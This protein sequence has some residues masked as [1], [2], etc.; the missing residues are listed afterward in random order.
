[1]KKEFNKEST[2]ATLI[3]N[4]VS[5]TGDPEKRRKI[6]KEI[7]KNLKWSGNYI[8]T[9][10]KKSAFHIAKTETAKGIKHIVICG[11]D[12]T[13]M[14]TLGAIVNK[15]ISLGIVPLGTGNLLAR[16]LDLPLDTKEALNIALFGN[17]REIDI[18]RANGM[19][20]SLIAGMGIDADIMKETKRE[21]K[22]A[23]GL[24]AYIALTLKNLQKR[25]GIYEITL[26][27]KKPFIVKAKTVMASNMGKL[28]GGI[29]IVPFADPQSGSLQ[30]GIIKAHSFTSWINISTHALFGR[31][32]NSPHY[33]VYKARKIKIR[34]LNGPK[35]YECDGNY[36]PKTELLSIDIYP[37]SIPV[38]VKRLI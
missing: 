10:K 37:Q 3:V 33:E 29:E 1:M 5:G 21:M 18:G 23:W 16:N 14:E 24:L 38:M 32:D 17:R 12:G 28:M 2:K 36:F 31:I 34:S 9:T 27:H 22:D 7:A 11:G 20:F 26:D 8:E 6:L 30:L 19:Y 35:I 4:P 25:S 15:K 13:I